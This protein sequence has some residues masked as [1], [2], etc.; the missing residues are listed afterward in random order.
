MKKHF[1]Q[2]ARSWFQLRGLSPVA[3]CKAE[4]LFWPSTHS[5][6]SPSSALS[7]VPAGLRIRN[8]RVIPVVC[9]NYVEPHKH[10]SGQ[11]LAGAGR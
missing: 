8:R 7:C 11:H 10:L 2:S 4:A 3:S 5:S 6:R 1:K 9:G